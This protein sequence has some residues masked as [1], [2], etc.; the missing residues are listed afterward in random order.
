MFTK[1]YY[2][3]LEKELYEILQLIGSELTGNE[4]KEVSEMIENRD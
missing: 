4:I 1:G 3:Q 2:E